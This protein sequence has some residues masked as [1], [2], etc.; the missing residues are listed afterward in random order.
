MGIGFPADSF[1]YDLYQYALLSPSIE[2][3]VKNLFPRTKIQF[4]FCYGHYD[5]S[6]HYLPLD[7][8]VGIVFP[9]IVVAVL[10]DRLMRGQFFQPGLIIVEKSSLVIVDEDGRR[11]VHGVY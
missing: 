8:R 2:L 3:P 10:V 7:V 1:S 9:S 4:P 11:D 6:P 5:F